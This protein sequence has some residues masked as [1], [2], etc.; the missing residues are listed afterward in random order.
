MASTRSRPASSL[1]ACMHPASSSATA[2][3]CKARGATVDARFLRQGEQIGRSRQ[4]SSVFVSTRV[5]KK[6]CL[7]NMSS[8]KRK[9][10]FKLELHGDIGYA[11][12]Q[13]RSGSV[14][15]KI[16]S[17]LTGSLHE[18]PKPELVGMAAWYIWWQRRQFGRGVGIPNANATAI[19][20]R[21]LK[22][23]PTWLR[24]NHWMSML[25]T[26]GTAYLRKGNAYGIKYK[27]P[28]AMLN[29]YATF[30]ILLLVETNQNYS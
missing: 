25:I 8:K 2:R 19:S 24:E 5:T 23:Q 10:V 16:L 1:S 12:A 26:R 18:I 20:I 15:M 22:T 9:H 29:F 28:I 14:T 17:S 3:F 27:F 11:V 30:I 7:Q 21:V 4:Y 13:D 6:T